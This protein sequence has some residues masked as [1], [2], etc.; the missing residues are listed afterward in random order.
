MY[1]DIGFL[2]KQ[3]NYALISD[4][5]PHKSEICHSYTATLICVSAVETWRANILRTITLEEHFVTREYL[6]GPGKDMSQMLEAFA[7][8]TL[9]VS[10]SKLI[11]QLLDLGEGRI[12]NMDAAGIDV[13]VLSLTRFG[14]VQEETEAIRLAQNSNDFLADAVKR[15]PT[16][17][18]GFAVLPIIV[19]NKA[20]DELERTVKEHNFKG[21]MIYGHSRGRYLDD[22]FFWPIL[23]RAEELNVPIYLHPT[24]PP[25]PVIKASYFG[26]YSREVMGLLANMGWGWHIETALHVLRIIVS[27]VFDTYPKLQLVI[28]HLGEALPFMMPRIERIFATQVTKLNRPIGDYLR[29]NIHYT[30][31]GFNYTQAF[32]DLLLQVGVERIMFSADYPYVSMMKARNFL[33]RLPVSPKDKERIAHGNAELLLRL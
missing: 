4:V 10:A 17:F 29:E 7:Q 11:D 20:A 15:Y 14:G 5:P 21:T 16:R 9:N 1:L 19:P 2:S 33:N 13:Q 25:E 28:G 12:S 23:A 26:N 30:F 24:P 6:E 3:K 8:S 22:K 27:G 18:A 31:S 32:L